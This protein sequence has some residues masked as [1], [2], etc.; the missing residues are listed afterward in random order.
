VNAKAKPKGVEPA[1]PKARDADRSK[2]AILESARREFATYGLGGSRLE[3]IAAEANVHKKLVYYYFK[4]KD[5][6]FAAVLESVYAEIR[7]AQLYL[8]LKDMEPLAALRRLVEFTW[9]YYIAHPEFIIFLNSENL[10]KARHLQG[11]PRIRELN[12]PLLQTL[13]D[14]V[15]RGQKAGLFR[16]GID[17]MQL[18]ITIAGC[19]YFY[20]SNVHTLSVGFSADLASPKMLGQRMSHILDVVTAYVLK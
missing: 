20:L 8:D 18:Y 12:S 3:R 9:D 2:L 5:G 11:A 16:G 4:D 13:A 19:S 17:P 10:H 7:D 1:E 6:L 15:E 14:I